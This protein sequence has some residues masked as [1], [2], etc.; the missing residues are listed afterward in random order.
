MRGQNALPT[1]TVSQKTERA[2]GQERYFV[3]PGCPFG[4]CA[5]ATSQIS[6]FKFGLL[7]L[8]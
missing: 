6:N 8:W 7:G 2:T 5:S 4:Y 3:L 1:K